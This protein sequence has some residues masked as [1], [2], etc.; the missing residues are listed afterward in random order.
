VRLS[1]GR[2]AVASALLITT[3]FVGSVATA[4]GASAATRSEVSLGNMMNHARHHYGRGGLRY[5]SGLS[6]LARRHSALM[7]KR[8]TIFH[9]ANLAYRLRGYSW[10]VA[11]ENV[12]MGPTMLALHQAFMASPH[13]RENILYRGYH[14]YG[15]GVVWKD[16]IAYVT[17]EFMG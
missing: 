9:T 10:R 1:L 13:H 2:R 14:R 7:A 11:G 16:G 4:P 3:L 12:G 8:G 17:V 6:I 5:S 15:V